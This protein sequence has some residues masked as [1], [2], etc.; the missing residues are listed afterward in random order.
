MENHLIFLGS[1]ESVIVTHI[2]NPSKFYVQLMKNSKTIE[3]MNKKFAQYAQH[4]AEPDNIELS[5]YIRPY[6]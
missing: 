4:A 6:R 5:K 1:V 2:V 3:A